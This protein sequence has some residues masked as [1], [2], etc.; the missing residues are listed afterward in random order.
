MIPR[1]HQLDES[2]LMHSRP[3]FGHILKQTDEDHR[4][5]SVWTSTLLRT[6]QTASKLPLPQARHLSHTHHTRSHELIVQTTARASAPTCVTDPVTLSLYQKAT[7]F[8]CDIAG[9]HGLEH[10]VLADSFE[11]A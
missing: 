8:G 11:R 2:L 5:I 9:V 3:L 7:Q 6:I 1:S 4:F 10:G